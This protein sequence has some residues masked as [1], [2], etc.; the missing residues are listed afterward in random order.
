[1]IPPLTEE[2]PPLAEEDQVGEGGDCR[3]IP[4]GPRPAA[5]AG[6]RRLLLPLLLLPLLL[7]PLLQGGRSRA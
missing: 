7:L 2:D 3:Q 4:R 5:E 6:I 1:M